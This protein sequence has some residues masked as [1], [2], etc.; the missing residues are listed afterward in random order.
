MGRG[1][2]RKGFANIGNI[3]RGDQL[4]RINR[5]IMFEM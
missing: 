1:L 5:Q 4:Y 3:I 2:V